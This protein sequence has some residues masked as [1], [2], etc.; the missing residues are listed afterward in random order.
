MAQPRSVAGAYPAI[1]ELQVPATPLVPHLQ[2][3]PPPGTPTI[4]EV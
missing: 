4:R 3:T 2:S 1:R